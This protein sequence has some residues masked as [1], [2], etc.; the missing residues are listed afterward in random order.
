MKSNIVKVINPKGEIREITITEGNF[1]TVG[2]SVN[3][4]YLG[5]LKMR[6][7]ARRLDSGFYKILSFSL[8]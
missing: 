6:T 8:K 3:G 2:Y 4:K 1:D 5:E 7:F